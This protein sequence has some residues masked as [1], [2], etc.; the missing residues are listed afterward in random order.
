[1]LFRFSSL[2]IAALALMASASA[3]ADGDAAT[4]VVTATRTPTKLSDVVAETTVIDREMLD[5]AA[6]RT[7]A[8]LVSSFAGVQTTSNGGLGKSASVFMRGLEARH[9]L[10]LVDGV[11][12]GS[13]TLGT[14]SLDNLPLEAV[15]RIEI[16]RGPLS[17]LYGNGAMGGVIQIFL[18][19]GAQGSTVNAKATAGSHG[20]G[21]LAG[22][23]TFGDGRFDAM[24]QVQRT[25]VSGV[26]ATNP[27]VPF[28]NHNPDEDGFRQTGG[29]LRLGWRP[30]ADWRAEL[31]AL[32]S[33]G[34]TQI[35]DGPG[36]DAR[37]RLKN[38]VVSLSGSGRV[39][40]GWRTRLTLAEST[41]GYDTLSSASPFATLGPIQSKI[42]QTSW[43]NT[44]DTAAGAAVVLLERQTEKVSRPGEPFSVSERDIDALALALNGAAGPH[45]W[46][47]SLR[48]DRNSQFGGKTTG[49]AGYGYALTPAWR[50]LGSV[51]TSFVAPS[52]NQLYYPS[53]GNPLLQPE[54]GRHGELGLRW[55]QGANSVRLATYRHTYKG[56]I[57]SG[58]QPT[59]VNAR[60]TGQTL[61]YE[62]RAGEFE[63]TAA[64]D[65][66]NPR[67][68]APWSANYGRQ[69]QRRAKDSLRAM[70]DWTRGPWTAGATLQA[71]TYRYDDAAN[72]TRLG[73]YATLDLRLAYALTRDLELAL[74][75]N[76]AGDKAYETALGYDQPGREAF[77]SLRYALK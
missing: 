49:A 8:E 37:A 2:S 56:F 61:S 31:L 58:A 15:D 19:Q 71:H 51:G 28:G 47:G 76:N 1:M 25:E 30:L 63:W 32:Q 46:N 65:H 77:V 50:V 18:R 36:A 29:S 26:S 69:L 20:Y 24:A 4:I 11:R 42:R 38:E 73:G 68:D 75:M 35:D 70:L 17:S 33:R 5:R 41:D 23:G 74:R 9:T 10:L 53:F 7:L 43:E 72:N 59:N 21:Q 27:K 48:R 16:V 12:V 40:D 3:R 14:P 57:T 55:S 13:A 60:I 45:V 64:A 67:N 62:G 22:G 6:G 52:F 66:T 44:L 39:N 54:T 34:T